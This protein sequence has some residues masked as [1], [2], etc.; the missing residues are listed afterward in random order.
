MGEACRTC[1]G[2]IPANCYRGGVPTKAEIRRYERDRKRL[3]RAAK[4]VAGAADLPPAPDMPGDLLGWAGALTVTQGE[5]AGDLLT[6][7]PWQTDYLRDVDA[8]AGGEYRLSVSAGAGNHPGG[9]RGRG[10]RCGALRG[11]TPFWAGVERPPS[12]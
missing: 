2:L 5:H 1:P 7:L 6:V 9:Y 12:Q 10:G 4:R 8:A 3:Q 11:A